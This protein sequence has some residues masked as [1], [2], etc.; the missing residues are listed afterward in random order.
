MYGI[1]WVLRDGDT[2][3]TKWCSY[4]KEHKEGRKYKA[5]V[6]TENVVCV[7]VKPWNSK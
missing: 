2:G 5:G 4:V 1:T 7:R 6:E 3:R